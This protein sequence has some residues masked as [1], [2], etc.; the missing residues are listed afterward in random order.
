MYLA[1]DQHG[2]LRGQLVRAIRAAVLDGRLGPGTR[3]PPT[4]ELAQHLGLSRSTVLAAYD[5]LRAEGCIEGK[6]GSGSYVA[7]LQ[8]ALP[9][10]APRECT[11]VQPSRFA[12]SLV[13]LPPF[14][15]GP[16]EPPLRYNLQYGEP[17][18]DPMVTTAWSHELAR[19]ARYTNPGYPP[20]QGLPAL[21]EA[22]CD[23][24]LHHR[25]VQADAAD[26]LIVNGTQQALSLTARILLDEGDVAVLEEPG[27]FGAHIAFKG[28]GARTLR[29]PTDTH[30]PVC[31]ALPAGGARL[32]FVTPSH[33]FPGGSV[34]SLTRRQALLQYADQHQGWI[35]EDDYD[36]EF[37]PRAQ[38]IAALHSIDRAARVIYSGTFSKALFP[39]LRLGYL[40]MP[41]ALRKCYLAAK[42]A[43]DFGS[44][45]VEQAAL[46]NFMASGA[47]ARHLRRAAKTLDARRRALLDG[48]QQWAG[49]RVEVA[50]GLGGMHLVVWLRDLDH[51][52][53]GQLIARGRAAGLSMQPIADHCLTPPARAGLL[54][55]Y[56]GI[57]AADLAQAT[58]LFGQC[59]D[60]FAP[61]DVPLPGLGQP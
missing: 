37:Q 45:A 2:H 13:E 5:Q 46:A 60:T 30:G 19:A 28:H 14:W 25:G 9:S 52:Q 34:M 39:G 6:V 16:R 44:S 23:Y 41:A 55:G 3:L 47:F 43:S 12:R 58:R 11:P 38:P 59:L 4:R 20:P 10:A 8:A 49:D 32:L 1:L 40:L 7:T 54:M 48:L 42:W 26:V 36:G 21:R 50:D 51:A 53:C 24:L 27:Y 31:D 57:S 33:Q 15:A 18:A 22:V 17:L 35:F 29:V 61:R 56:A